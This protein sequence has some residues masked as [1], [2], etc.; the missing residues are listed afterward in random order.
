MVTAVAYCL[1]EQHWQIEETLAHFRLSKEMP[2]EGKRRTWVEMEMGL[3]RQMQDK[4][5]VKM[6]PSSIPSTPDG[7]GEGL[8]GA[9]VPLLLMP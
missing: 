3:R 9:D 7:T 5:V 1:A 2:L 4:A 6:L 8:L